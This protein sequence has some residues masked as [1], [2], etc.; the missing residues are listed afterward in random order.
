LNPGVPIYAQTS[1]CKWLGERMDY[2][3]AIEGM[4]FR[5]RRATAATNATVT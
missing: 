1:P 5:D 3:M 4:Q 2:G